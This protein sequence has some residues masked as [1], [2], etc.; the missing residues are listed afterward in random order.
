MFKNIPE[1]LHEPFISD[2]FEILQK[3]VSDNPEVDVYINSQKDFAFLY[4]QP[5]LDYTDYLPRVKKLNLENYKK[6]NSVYEDRFNKISPFLKNNISSLIE[7]GAAA[8]SFLE[9]VKRENPDI[10][11]AA[12]EPDTNTAS[13]REEF[14]GAESY[15]SLD[16]IC[17]SNRKYDV[18]CFFHVLE[19]IVDPSSFLLKLRQLMHSDTLIIIEVPS[20]FDPLLSL[21]NCE[22][23]KRFYFQ[24]Q[25]PYVY[26]RPSITRLMKYNDFKA[27]EIIDF[28]RYGL[29]NHLNWLI[30]DVP[31]GNDLLREIFS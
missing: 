30:N 6:I 19:H 1:K 14:V 11:L 28:Q 5:V 9:I 2:K 24:A 31:G 16:E 22:S 29:E 12:V 8:G 21:Y 27:V 4:P 10:K 13:L 7:I 18:I 25:H 26:S 23:Y 20:L 3:G 17:S 15:A